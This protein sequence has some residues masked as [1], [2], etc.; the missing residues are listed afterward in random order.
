MGNVKEVLVS[1][2]GDFFFAKFG[3]VTIVRRVDAE[4][5][6]RYNAALFPRIDCRNFVRK[7]EDWNERGEIEVKIKD[8]QGRDRLK[9]P[10]PMT[11]TDDM[12]MHLDTKIKHQDRNS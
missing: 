5:L 4:R 2:L 12:I 11:Q 3:S 9:K 10:L 6:P 8:F 7:P 1:S